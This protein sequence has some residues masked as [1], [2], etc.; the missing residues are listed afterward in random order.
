[1]AARGVKNQQRHRKN[2]RK[3]ERTRKILPN[4]RNEGLRAVGGEE[5]FPFALLLVDACPNVF[6]EAE[7]LESAKTLLLSF[8]EDGG[9][10]RSR[11]RGDRIS[12]FEEEADFVL[13]ELIVGTTK[14]DLG[15]ED[16]E[17]EV[18]RVEEG[19][20]RSLEGVEEEVVDE[21]AKAGLRVGDTF[22]G[23]IAEE[24]KVEDVEEEAE[25]EL[26]EVVEEVELLEDEKHAAASL[27]K[28]QVLVRNLLDL[29]HDG[30]SLLHLA[31]N[32]RRF[33]LERLESLDNP[34]RNGRKLVNRCRA[35]R[36]E[37]NVL[38]VIED[39]TLRLVES[40]EQALLE[41]VEAGAELALQTKE[42]GA[43]L[44]DL[45]TL[46]T[47]NMSER[48]RL[49][50]STSD[51][52]ERLSVRGRQKRKRRKRTEKLTIVTRELRSAAN[53]T[54]GSR[55]ERNML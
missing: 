4:R 5:R 44:V 36:K 33:P 1:M 31:S 55:V 47:K 38:V 7:T 29:R 24:D 46:N 6:E 8:V 16:G 13:V 18:V 10:V 32:V 20:G 54:D 42:V 48:L 15:E 53:S 19:T 45:G 52:Y 27:R 39:V 28:W 22:E 43:F 3:E 51:L 25:G 50:T 26:V 34:A 30:V 37:W 49:K 40:R 2:E 23:G 21:D 41:V 9:T 35:R 12:S 17:S 11:G 14:L